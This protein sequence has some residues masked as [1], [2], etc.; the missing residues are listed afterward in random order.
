MH[1]HILDSTPS[2]SIDKPSLTFFVGQKSTIFG[3]RN[4]GN[5]ENIKEMNKRETRSKCLEIDNQIKKNKYVYTSRPILKLIP[6]S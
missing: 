4:C 2:K 1:D 6:S 3:Q 5:L